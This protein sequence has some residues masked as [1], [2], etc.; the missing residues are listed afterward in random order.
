VAKK[1]LATEN[2][3]VARPNPQVFTIPLQRVSNPYTLSL[4]RLAVFA[5]VLIQTQA[6]GL[7]MSASIP[8]KIKLTYFDIDG[9]VDLGHKPGRHASL[10]L[11]LVVHVPKRPCPYAPPF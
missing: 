3:Q 4:L 5:L 7:S 2:P 11:L 9:C 8:S 1:K 10:L 6:F